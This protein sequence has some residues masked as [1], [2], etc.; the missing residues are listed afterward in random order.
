MHF[1]GEELLS[2]DVDKFVADIFGDSQHKK[3]IKSIANAALG[4]ISSGSLIIHRIGHV[5]ADALNLSG[6]AV[7]RDRI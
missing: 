3:R 1:Q 7:R 4:E 6:I 2:F 5:L